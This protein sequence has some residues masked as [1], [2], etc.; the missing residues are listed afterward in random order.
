LDLQELSAGDGP[1]KVRL[2]LE[3]AQFPHAVI[4]QQAAVQPGPGPSPLL[5]SQNRGAGSGEAPLDGGSL[6]ILQV[7]YPLSCSPPTPPPDTH[8][9]FQA[10]ILPSVVGRA[11]VKR[12]VAGSNLVSDDFHS[13][14]YF[15]AVVGFRSTRANPGEGVRLGRNPRK[16]TQMK[17]NFSPSP[18]ALVQ[19]ANSGCKRTVIN[20]S[21]FF[22]YFQALGDSRP[23]CRVGG[24]GG[25]KDSRNRFMG[26]RELHGVR[27]CNR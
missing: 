12:K 13:A 6:I 22:I 19:L 14:P 17:D 24:G 16:V 4:Y 8:T 5:G 7:K 25:G 11:A 20:P 1:S 2:D 23:A 10:T 26:T 21:Y 9:N 3:L 27:P 15:L 18:K